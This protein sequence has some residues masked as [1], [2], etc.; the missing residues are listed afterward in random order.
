MKALVTGGSGFIGTH[1]V[2]HLV[3]CGD[4]VINVDYAKPG[5]EGKAAI[6]RTNTFG[7]IAQRIC[8]G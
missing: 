4:E 3:N 6:G 2:A 1:L 7:I 5:D 8:K